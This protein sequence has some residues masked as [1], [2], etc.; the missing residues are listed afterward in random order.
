MKKERQPITVNKLRNWL[1][2]LPEDTHV[3]II[4]ENKILEPD[5]LHY[6]SITAT[7]VFNPIEE[8]NEKGNA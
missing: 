2:T 1:G 3:T 7:I 4:C 8:K 5:K 6:D